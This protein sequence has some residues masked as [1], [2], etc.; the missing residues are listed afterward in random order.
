MLPVYYNDDLV[1]RL[2]V[3]HEPHKDSSKSAESWSGLTAKVATLTLQ[4]MES[5]VT[6]YEE[7]VRSARERRTESTWDFCQYFLLQVST[8]IARYHHYMHAIEMSFDLGT[9]SCV[10]LSC[11]QSFR[12]NLVDPYSLFIRT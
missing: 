12:T 4:S 5:A 1:T 7:E 2:Y 8:T 3:L 10:Y 9:L 6:K 11:V